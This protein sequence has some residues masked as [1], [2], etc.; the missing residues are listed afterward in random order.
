MT[1]YIVDTKAINLSQKEFLASGGFGSV[2]VKSDTAYKIYTD[3]ANMIPIGKFQELS[4]LDHPSIIKPEKIILDEHSKNV[5]YTMKFVDDNY[6]LCQ[7]FT[8][9]FKEKNNIDAQTTL[10]LVR[11]LQDIVQYIH[12]KHILVVDLNEMII[13]TTI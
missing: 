7:L 4:V 6:V 11:K 1:K 8:K 2:Y 3:P 12:S 5:G 9:I 13:A 10:N